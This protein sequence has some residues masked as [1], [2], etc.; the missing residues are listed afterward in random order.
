MTHYLPHLPPCAT[1]R[2]LALA[3]LA[4]AGLVSAP[5]HAY[6]PFDGT[7]AG[8]AEAGEYEL[9]FSP[10]G[11]LR[12]GTGRTLM[13]P[14]IVNNFGLPGDV[15]I[16]LEGRLERDLGDTAGHRNRVA[17]T[18]VVVKHL[19][20]KGALQGEA[21]ASIAAECGVFLREVHGDNGGGGTCTG[22]VSRHVGPVTV[23]VNAALARNRDR[24][25]G[26]YVGIIVEGRGDNLRP[27][28]EVFNERD[29]RGGRVNSAL[30]GAA[31]RWR[32][33]LVFDGGIRRAREDGENVTEVRVGLT[34]T[35]SMR[36]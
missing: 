5:A 10:A 25:N 23:H 17:D 11:Y 32:D 36:N 1:V 9:E 19:F 4:A 28:I 33:G 24:S 12:H 14:A 35:V 18:A 15:E 16:A 13:G 3:C 31:W 8:V 21:G 7:D 2:K 26:R 6:R 22:A 29:N 34:W 30:V 27:A 20:R